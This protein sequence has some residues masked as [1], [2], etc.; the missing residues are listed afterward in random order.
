M[1]KLDH[2]RALEYFL[3]QLSN[4][5]FLKNSELSL[6]NFNINYY[7]MF[8][9]ILILNRRKIGCFQPDLKFTGE[10]G[11]YQSG[12]YYETPLCRGS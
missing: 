7:K 4:S 12:A 1:S 5:Q 3:L 10:A 11:A 9:A 2:F 8:G 6:S